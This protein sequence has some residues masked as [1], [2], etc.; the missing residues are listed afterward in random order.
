MF[1]NKITEIIDS[2]EE[3]L[4]GIARKIWENPGFQGAG[5]GVLRCD[6]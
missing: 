6:R 4:I 3:E 2:Y 1:K 5:F